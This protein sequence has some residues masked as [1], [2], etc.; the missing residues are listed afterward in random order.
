MTS[1]AFG[2][3]QLGNAFSDGALSNRNKIING[4]MQVAQRGT[5][6]A[7]VTGSGYF[8]TDRVL[9]AL[10]SLGTWTVENSSDAPSG[11]ARSHKVIC[12]TANASPASG[13]YYILQWR[14]EGQNLQ[15][16]A[17]G[18]AAATPLT[19]SF[20][21]KSN[22]TGAA[23]LEFLQLDNSGKLW[24]NSYTINAA[25]TWE[26][27]TVVVPADASGVINNDNG[28]GLELN[29]W[30]NSGTT[31]SSGSHQTTW[32]SYA[33]ANRNV[34]NLAVGAAV[35]DYLAITG[36][37]LEAGDTATPFEHRSYGAELALCQ[38]YYWKNKPSSLYAYIA[39]GVSRVTYMGLLIQ[40]PQVMR[41]APTFNYSNLAAE[42]GTLTT[43]LATYAGD[44]S[45]L[46]QVN[47]TSGPASGDLNILQS[48]SAGV[49]FLEASAEL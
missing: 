22:K 33:D 26:Y 7:S 11:F 44:T 17:Y 2:L 36:V 43:A 28:T 30:V 27:K 42:V 23:S 31:F 29:F 39:V 35:S 32:G 6:V 18:T 15:D 49:G 47:T 34:S 4:A 20:W 12:T 10:D 3:A 8:T 37:Q 46:Y 19:L 1:K 41:A 5:S 21:V 40:Y 25:D 13:A 24:S 9:Q 38:R 48:A 14:I 16:L 45:A